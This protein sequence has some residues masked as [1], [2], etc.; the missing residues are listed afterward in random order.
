MYIHEKEN[1]TEF[2]W[3]NEKILPTLTSV[4]HSHGRFL[5]QME[6]LG[7]DFTE[8]ATINSDKRH[9]EGVSV[10]CNAARKIR[11]LV[12]S[13]ERVFK[14]RSDFFLWILKKELSLRR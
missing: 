10:I 14:W 8:K 13:S 1:W 7:F 9:I 11:Q 4:R 6:R 12:I 2:R 5:G 3:D